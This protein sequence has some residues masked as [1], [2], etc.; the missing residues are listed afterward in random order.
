V[1]HLGY[2]LKHTGAALITMIFAMD[3]TIVKF[4]VNLP[5]AAETYLR[6]IMTKYRTPA[7]RFSLVEA[8]KESSKLTISQNLRCIWCRLIVV[9]FIMNNKRKGNNAI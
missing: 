4:S 1:V 3:A 8:P 7:V 6:K 2:D 9:R 5:S